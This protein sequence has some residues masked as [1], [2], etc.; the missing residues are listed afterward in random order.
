MIYMRMNNHGWGAKEMIFC[1]AIILIAF[2]FVVFYTSQLMEGLGDTFRQNITG[3]ITYSSIEENVEKSA[4]AYMSKYYKNE[5]GMGTI[6]IKSSNLIQYGILK[7]SDFVTSEKDSCYGYALVRRD[8]E[9][10][11][12]EPYITCSKYETDH[13]QSWRLGE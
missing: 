1:S 7:E 12:A 4:L 13:Y 11:M 6:T 8:G 10:L 2:F 9:D 3:N 5:V